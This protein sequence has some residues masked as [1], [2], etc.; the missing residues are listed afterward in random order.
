MSKTS[1]KTL[2]SLPKPHG[3][4]KKYKLSPSLRKALEL[5]CYL[6]TE[7]MKDW[8]KLPDLFDPYFNT[9]PVVLKEGEELYISILNYLKAMHKGDLSGKNN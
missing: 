2:P 3:A 9:A 6:F 4:Y 8:A 1:H 7:G 5:P